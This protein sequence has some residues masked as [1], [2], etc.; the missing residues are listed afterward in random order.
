MSDDNGVK[1]TL[2]DQVN[3]Y[4]NLLWA[5]VF[6]IMMGSYA[7]TTAMWVSMN[8]A[9][10]DNALAIALVASDLR[11]IR[12]KQIAVVGQA[13]YIHKSLFDQMA[14]IR[15]RVERSK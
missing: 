4:R 1:K 10:N 14:E 11:T 3:E 15:Q 6:V 5:S 9:N 7:Y 12:E 2:A 13:D 8:K